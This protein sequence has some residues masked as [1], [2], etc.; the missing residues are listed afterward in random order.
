[1]SQQDACTLLD[2]DH[3]TVE[4]LFADYRSAGKDLDTKSRLAQTVCKELTVHAILEEE[5]F[6]PAL[7]EA[8]G[9]GDLV[10]EAEVEHETVKDLITEIEDAEKMDPL[11]DKLQKAVEHHVKEERQKMFPKARATSGLDL[12]ALGAQL[13]T[14]K[15]E[16]TAEPAG[17]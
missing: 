2:N 8:T 9:D 6:Y 15:S 17:E 16:L 7:R 14:R 3:Q 11:M 5:I 12:V 13:K 1:M 10:E 4:R